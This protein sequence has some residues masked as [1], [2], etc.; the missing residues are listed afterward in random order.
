MRVGKRL[1]PYP[2]LNNNKQYSQYKNSTLSLEYN[3]VITDEYLIL[4]NIRCNIDCNYMKA[5]LNEGFAEAVCIVEC[6]QTMLRKHYILTDDMNDIKI[7]LMDINGKVD[8]SLFIVAKRDI[9]NYKCNDFLDDYSDYDF[10]VEKNDIIG[11][12]DGYTSRI[13]FNEKESSE[14][15]SIFIV[16]KD[17][18]ITDKTMRVERADEKIIISLPQDQW[19][20]YDKTNR[21]RKFQNLYFAIIAVPALSY[22][23]AEMQRIGDTIDNIRIEK[24]WFNAFCIAYYNRNGEELT[25]EYFMQMNPYFEAQKLLN[26]PVIKAMDDI[27]GLTMTMGGMDDGN[28]Y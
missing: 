14:K 4:D 9:A 28:Q 15:S 10:F 23:L 19:N 18:N 24:K 8:I 20:E 17:T 21:I 13:E 3:E 26:S 7:P 25:D 1:F 12:D 2:V 27:F 22:A 6:P 16:I 5:L 11:I